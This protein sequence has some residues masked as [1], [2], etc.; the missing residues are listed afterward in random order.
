[1]ALEWVQAG[2]DNVAPRILSGFSHCIPVMA[3]N[4]DGFYDAFLLCFGKSF[5]IKFTRFRPIAVSHTMHQQDI[6]ILG[7][8]FLPEAVECF[9]DRFPFLRTL[10]IRPHFCHQGDLFTG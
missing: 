4:T 1:M 5:H 2:Q 6:E 8:G 7:T 3:R 10:V 9:P